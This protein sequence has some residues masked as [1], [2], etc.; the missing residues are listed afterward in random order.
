MLAL[1]S[2]WRRGYLG[3]LEFRRVFASVGGLV[4]GNSLHYSKFITLDESSN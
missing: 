3:Q 1:R 2:E 4:P